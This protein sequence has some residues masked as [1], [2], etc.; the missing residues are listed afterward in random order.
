MTAPP[1]PFPA[2]DDSLFVLLNGHAHAAWLDALMRALT[3]ASGVRPLLYALALL[4]VLALRGRARAN[5]VLA[6][7]AVAL[8]DLAVARGLKP[9]VHRARPADAG[10]PVRALV[11]LRHSLGFPSAHAVNLGAFTAALAARGSRLAWPAA[12]LAAVVGYSRV[13]VGVHRPL[14]VLWGWLLGIG[15]GLLCA[16]AW[17]RLAALGRARA[18]PRP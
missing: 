11:E 8:A 4:P 5:W 2:W 13:Y 15:V 12:L 1:I 14:D 17:E 10:L 7:L 3:A 6:W 18:A 9:W 16:L